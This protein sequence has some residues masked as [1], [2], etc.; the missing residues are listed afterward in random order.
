MSWSVKRDKLN[1]AIYK[2]YKEKHF[3]CPYN[4]E[5]E[6][7]GKY[8]PRLTLYLHPY[9]FEEDA[10]KNLTLSAELT[11]S[12]KSKMSSSA[13]ILINVTASESSERTKLR[14]VTL[15]CPANCRIV[16]E[17]AF[18]SHDEL[19]QLECEFIEF[20]ASAKLY[21]PSQRQSAFYE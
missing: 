5:L 17:K 8:P 19:K 18:L 10:G 1:E 20:H 7:A 14:E 13:T 6:N 16:W 4:L 15:N 21:Y 3:K 2:P 11:A 12:V 9:G